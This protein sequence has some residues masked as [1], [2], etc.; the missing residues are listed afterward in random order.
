MLPFTF[1]PQRPPDQ[2]PDFAFR[3]PH[4][5]FLSPQSPRQIPL[6]T[7]PAHRVR[8]TQ[9]HHLRVV[10]FTAIGT[11]AFSLFCVSYTTLRLLH[12]PIRA[13]GCNG[14][15][16]R[17]CLSDT[18]CPPSTH[19]LG[20]PCPWTRTSS[21]TRAMPPP[22]G[23]LSRGAGAPKAPAELHPTGAIVVP[24]KRRRRW[25]AGLTK[26]RATPHMTMW[27]LSRRPWRQRHGWTV[28]G[29]GGTAHGYHLL[30]PVIVVFICSSLSISCHTV[31]ACW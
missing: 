26:P 25:S 23:K 17:E 24:D 18:G 11:S 1:R 29:H 6:Q 28:R 30:P 2:R 22:S 19:P 31:D 15:Q 21:P 14:T 12:S 16:E 7:H 9:S 20:P 8:L 27:V 3:P 5:D 13:T 4:D 10:D